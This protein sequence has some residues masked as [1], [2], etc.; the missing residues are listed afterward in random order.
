MSGSPVRVSVSALEKD[1]CQAI[2]GIDDSSG[3]YIGVERREICV[4]EYSRTQISREATAQGKLPPAD[5]TASVVLTTV[6][7]SHA[8]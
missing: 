7:S 3:I 6:L 2:K 5:F 8:K 4:R 1:E